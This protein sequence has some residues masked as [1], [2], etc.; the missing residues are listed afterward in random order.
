MDAASVPLLL[1]L[2]AL[3]VASGLAS[4][5]ETALFSMTHGE[6]AEL[7]RTAPRTAAAVEHMLARPRVLL[8]HILL[9]NM[10]VNV[11]YFVVSSVLTLQADSP[12]LSTT[13]SVVAVLAIILFGEV[14][15]KLIASRARIAFAR[16]V[17]IPLDVLRT[18]VLPGLLVLDR[19]VIAPLV[20]LVQPGPA[21]PGRV[22]V[23]EMSALV[24]EGGRRGVLDDEE[25]RL[26]AEVLELGAIRVRE[27]MTP[28]GDIAWVRA[29]A[30]IDEVLDVCRRTG[31][32]KLLV[33]AGS[34]DDEVLGLAD[35]KRVLTL[36]SVRAAMRPPRFVPEHVGLDKLLGHFRATGASVAPVV[37]ER[38]ELA[39]VVDIQALVDELL[40]GLGEQDKP[41]REQIQMVRLGVWLAPGRLSVRDWA[42]SFDHALDAEDLDRLEHTDRVSTLGGLIQLVLGR[43]P[44]PGDVVRVGSV[45]LAVASMD[46][47]AVGAV[48]VRLAD[49]A[50]PWATGD[51]P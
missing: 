16:T 13:I 39:G 31:R 8:I 48:E 49:G 24:A 6:R 44:K 34:L 46:G 22:T 30:P 27:V 18:L 21:G 23:E 33:R 10:L 51:R 47:R 17:A 11:T 28:R 19:F 40:V 2:P 50:E 32:T 43:L 9:L 29:D 7:R 20:R 37:D 41:P 5:S 26:L 1:M 15:A 36:G 12:A 45:E 42:Q 25:E 35:V 38:G 4:G 3:L 14:L